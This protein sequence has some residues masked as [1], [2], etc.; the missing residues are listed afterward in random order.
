MG[1][2]GKGRQGTCIKDTW[3]KITVGGLNVEV[4]ACVGQGRVMREKF[5]QLQLNNN[6][7]L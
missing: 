7:F 2:K 4:G 3:T 1:K 5:G 6:K